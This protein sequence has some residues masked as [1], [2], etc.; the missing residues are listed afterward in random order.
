M[1]WKRLQTQTGAKT[2]AQKTWNLR[3]PDGS[4]TCKFNTV[5]KKNII[6]CITVGVHCDRACEI[7][8]VRFELSVIYAF[9]RSHLTSGGSKKKRQC[10][11]KRLG[12]YCKQKTSG[13]VKKEEKGPPGGLLLIVKWG[14][15]TF[16]F[17]A[18]RLVDFDSNKNQISLLRFLEV[19][20]VSSNF[21]F[22]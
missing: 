22:Q 1:V 15:L 11:W 7:K 9:S 3:S 20:I 5:S 8:I 4:Y 6:G 2:K 12:V 19:F 21:N 13:D 18:Y 10:F 16:F 17:L 14:D